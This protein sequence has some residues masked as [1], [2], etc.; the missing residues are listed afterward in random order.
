MLIVVES[1]SSQFL[2]SFGN[3]EALTPNLDKLAENS[4]L[5][6]NFYATGTRTVRGLEAVTLSIPPTPG[7]SIVKRPDNSHMFS[8]GYVLRQKGYDTRYMYGGYSY[9]D[10]MDS[11]FSG[12]SFTVIDRSQFDESRIAFA[13]IW[14]IS[15]ED[16]F[17]RAITEA[18]QSYE[19]RQPF[20]TMVMTTSNHTPYT[21]PEGRIDI[22]PGSGRNGAVK[23]TDYAIGQLLAE[24]RQQ[25]WFEDT[26]FVFVADHCASSAGRTSLPVER[27]KIPLLIYAPGHVPTR[28]VSTLASQIDVAPTLLALLN[29]DYDSKFFGKNILGISAEE[30]RALI[31]N[32]QELGLLTRN[33]LAVLEPKKDIQFFETPFGERKRSIPS[34]HHVIDNLVSYYEGASYIY[35]HGLNKTEDLNLLSHQPHSARRSSTAN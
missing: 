9:F 12:N 35:K 8:L 2:G 21:Y 33:Y 22:A 3:Q 4:L 26:I 18:S 34:D 25:A 19:N 24:A 7:R 29:M 15:D 16:V 13:N 30:E 10:N 32:Y 20:F 27:Y 5:F 28:K 1:L 31:S 17:H 14:G 23:Y 6:T 11:F